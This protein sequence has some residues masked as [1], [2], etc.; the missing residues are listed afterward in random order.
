M[1]GLR[2]SDVVGGGDLSAKE[3]RGIGDVFHFA[4]PWRSAL[5]WMARQVHD[6]IRRSKRKKRWHYC[7][8]INLRLNFLDVVAEVGTQ[9]CCLRERPQAVGFDLS[10]IGRDAC[11]SDPKRPRISVDL[12]EKW[13]PWSGRNIGI[14]RAGTA[15]CIEQRRRIAD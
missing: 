7:C 6:R 4:W 1:R 13:P 10:A 14:A 2:C 15:S 3:T 12:L 11:K 8:A 9:F 5:G